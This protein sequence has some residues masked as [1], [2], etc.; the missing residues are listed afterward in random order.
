MAAPFPRVA[1]IVSVFALLLCTF[2][3]HAWECS[4]EPMKGTTISNGARGRG[5]TDCC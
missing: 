1:A 3:L 2:V 5:G 4:I